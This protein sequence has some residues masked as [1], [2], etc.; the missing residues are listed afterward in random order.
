[1]KCQYCGSEN[2]DDKNFCGVCGSPLKSREALSIRWQKRLARQTGYILALISVLLIVIAIGIKA[3]ADKIHG[4]FDF[5]VPVS[6]S[7]LN[8]AWLF[9]LLGIAGFF[10]AGLAYVF[11]LPTIIRKKAAGV[12]TME[13]PEQ[14]EAKSP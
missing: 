3:Q 14:K 7:L 1:M 11:S 13:N 8:I 10:V 4:W 5:G 9:A 2:P 6:H 12:A